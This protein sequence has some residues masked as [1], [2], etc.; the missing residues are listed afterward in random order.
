MW[1][2]TRWRPY[3]TLLSGLRHS[4][5]H[6]A[7]TLLAVGI[8]FSLPAAAQ[9]VLYDWWPETQADTHS[10]LATEVGLSV[11]LVLL[12]N[13]LK[14]AWDSRRMI[15]AGR[16][17]SLVYA[18]DAN[19]GPSRQKAKRLVKKSSSPRDVFVMTLTGF[20]TF[21]EPDSLF[22]DVLGTAYEIRVLLLDPRCAAA[23]RRVDAIS[24]KHVNLQSLHDEIAASIAYLTA[25]YKAGKRVTLKFY[26]QEPLWKVV[27]VGDNVWVQHFHHGFEVKRQPE[28]VFALQTSAPR[29]G[30][31]VPFYT[32]F[33]DH[34][35]ERRHPIYDF[36]TGELIYR[37]EGDNE[38]RRV[39]L[40]PL[41]EPGD[42][43]GSPILMP[44]R[45]ISIETLG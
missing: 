21:V 37:E 11:A 42:L 5:S 16:L 2:Y 18:T 27:V 9:F 3:H 17:A 30:F 31:Y 38:T 23:S 39:P 22:H 26:E 19:A 20:D 25:L 1:Q 24:D 35:N 44:S 32:Y 36:E 6:I 41:E 34:W 14:M 8:A 4:L 45:N 13:V 43:P 33:L 15:A 28:Y 29:Q 12:F 40:H 10:L 7:I